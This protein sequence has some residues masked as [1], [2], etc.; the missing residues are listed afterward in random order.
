MHAAEREKLII[1][2]VSRTGFV[3]Y[4]DLE[5]QLDASP[6]TIRRDLTRLEEEGQI[7]RV[8]GGAKL[9]RGSAIRPAPKIDRH[10]VRQGARS[11][12]CRKAGDRRSR[13]AALPTERRRHHR[14][15]HYNVPNV[16]P[17]G[18][19][20]PPSAHQFAAHRERAPA[21]GRDPDPG[22]V[23]YD[24]PR[25]EH[26]PGSLGRGQHAQ[27][28]REQAVLRRRGRQPARHLPD[29]ILV[30]SQRRL[31]ELAE[32]VILVVDSTKLET[33]S[34]AIMCELK[35]IDR[36]ITDRGADPE[37]L[38]AIRTAGVDVIVVG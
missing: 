6:A 20:P 21:A 8:H 7:E 2:A 15:R 38:E 18:R 16:S 4:R 37:R 36:M 19:T 12:H 32:E 33:T 3:T 22:A 26:H 24:L 25:A 11:E 35:S 31:L 30:A 13:R 23:R 29:A 9:R 5:A 17:P 14:R 1:G 34:G 27:F 10:S 28:S